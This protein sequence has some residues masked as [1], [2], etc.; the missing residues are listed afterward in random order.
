MSNLQT[1]LAALG[2]WTPPAL[3][4][5]IPHGDMPGDKVCIDDEPIRKANGIFPALLR[6]L[7]GGIGY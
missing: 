6:A 3:P 5:E 1:T 7:A 4:A 2:G